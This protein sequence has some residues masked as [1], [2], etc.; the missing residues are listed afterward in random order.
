MTDE[1]GMRLGELEGIVGEEDGYSAETDAA[2]SAARP[3]HSRRTAPAQDERAAGR[4][5]GPRAAG[6]GAVR[7]SRRRC[8]STSRRTTWTWTRST[9]CKDFLNDYDGVVDRHLARP[10]FPEQRLHPHRRHRLRDH[11]HLHRQLRRHGGGQDAGSLADR[12]R[13]TRSAKRRSRS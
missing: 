8:C 13:R 7:A 9:G 1:D 5:E 6:A 3:R 4:A 12:R 10:P 11:H 2:H